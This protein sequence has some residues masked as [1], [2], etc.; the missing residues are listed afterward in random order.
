MAAEAETADDL[1]PPSVSAI[2]PA[3]NSEDTIERA[4]TSVYA[5]TYPNIIDVIVVDDGSSDGTAEVVKA[6]FPDVRYVYQEN[7][8]PGRARNH[9]A[10]LARGDYIAFLDADDAWLPEKTKIQVGFMRAHPGLSMLGTQC[11][12][13]FRSFPETLRAH[14]TQGQDGVDGGLEHLP[15]RA[16]ISQLGGARLS[17]WLIRRPVF[18]ATAGFTWPAFPVEDLDFLLRL[19]AL[20]NSVGIVRS[21]QCLLDLSE[22]A[23]TSARKPSKMRAITN[24]PDI[25]AQLD[26]A[27]ESALN[28]LLTPLE[29]SALRKHHL[30]RLALWALRLGEFS[31]GFQQ[32]GEARNL[33]GGVRDN[34]LAVTVVSLAKLLRT[35]LGPRYASTVCQLLLG[36]LARVLRVLGKGA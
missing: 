18:V 33:K 30:L 24:V 13:V 34:L 5:Q 15:L 21:R 4:L 16:V 25:L 12:H 17:T 32:L 20:G 31:I 7:A 36:G 19:T 22:E 6:K 23:H 9:G 26:P 2:I 28:R 27:S 10:S 3:Y 14:L 29:Y 11:M 1:S 35:A 8:G